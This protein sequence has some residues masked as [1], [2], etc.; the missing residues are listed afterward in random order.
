[1][2]SDPM[3]GGP[4]AHLRGICYNISIM[5]LR[6]NFFVLSLIAIIASGCSTVQRFPVEH[7]CLALKPSNCSQS[8]QQAMIGE[9]KEGGTLEKA[10]EVLGEQPL[11]VYA[12]ETNDV[13]WAYW[14]YTKEEKIVETSVFDTTKT[15]KY[16]GV[17]ATCKFVNGKL[18]GVIMPNARWGDVESTTENDWFQLKYVATML[19][20]NFDNWNRKQWYFND[21]DKF[22]YYGNAGCAVDY[23]DGSK[24]HFKPDPVPPGFYRVYE[25]TYDGNTI[26]CDIPNGE[27][28][29]GYYDGMF[30]HHDPAAGVYV[31][32][33]VTGINNAALNIANQPRNMNSVPSSVGGNTSAAKQS[34]TRYT[35][36]SSG[37][38]ERTCPVCKNP[39]T[40]IHCPVCASKLRFAQ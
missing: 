39:F 14:Y 33:I 3:E 24:L 19:Q 12:D 10:I 11:G 34:P 28:Y 8:R 23:W 13:F 21:K 36:P 20:K 16:D 25:T 40:G 5:S 4:L 1:M 30:H 38:A 37:I 18:V 22:Y 29:D 35:Q 31:N 2:G 26:Y 9:I 27:I 32:A 17:W 7:G 15:Y 6:T